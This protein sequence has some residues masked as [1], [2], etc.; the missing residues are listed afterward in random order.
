[1]CVWVVPQEWDRAYYRLLR[2][3]RLRDVGLKMLGVGPHTRHDAPAYLA[4]RVEEGQ[5]LPRVQVGCVR[6]GQGRGLQCE[7]V[8]FVLQGLAV[9]VVVELLEV[10]GR[11]R[12]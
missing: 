2:A 12:A 3:R 6:G 10:L 1:M 8:G 4:E 5:S 9:E 11:W 7:V